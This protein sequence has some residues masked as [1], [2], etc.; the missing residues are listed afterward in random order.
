MVR[1]ISETLVTSQSKGRVTLNGEE[2][3]RAAVYRN[4]DAILR[5]QELIILGE[6]SSLFSCLVRHNVP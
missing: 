4:V 3:W 5:R 2:V 1:E 6:Y